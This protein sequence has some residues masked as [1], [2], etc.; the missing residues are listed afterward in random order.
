MNF[1]VSDKLLYVFP[2]GMGTSYS[3]PRTP[4]DFLGNMEDMDTGDGGNL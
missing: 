1:V 4:D 2:G 3:L